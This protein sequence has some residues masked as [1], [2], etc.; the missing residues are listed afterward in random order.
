MQTQIVNTVLEF[1]GISNKQEDHKELQETRVS[2]DHIDCV[3]AHSVSANELH[4][5]A[6]S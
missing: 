5:C 1:S 6:F 4:V 2:R 3:Y